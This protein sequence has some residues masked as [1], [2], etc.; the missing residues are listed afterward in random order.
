MEVPNGIMK[1]ISEPE[2]YKQEKAMLVS[3]AA[4][5]N[6]QKHINVK[7]GLPEFRASPRR[8]S[9]WSMTLGLI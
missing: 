1:G 3:K 8:N 6:S 7:R 9:L 4:A 5:L 2:P